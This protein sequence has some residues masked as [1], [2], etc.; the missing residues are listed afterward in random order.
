MGFI[1]VLVFGEHNGSLRGFSV[2]LRSMSFRGGFS[3][4]S[5]TAKITDRRST[6]SKWTMS[7]PVFSADDGC[8]GQ[9]HAARKRSLWLAGALIMLL[10]LS[11]LT[12]EL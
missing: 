4:T 12:L 9:R 6:S 10:F 8:V 3:T 11:A 7:R 2:G 1:Q 5:T